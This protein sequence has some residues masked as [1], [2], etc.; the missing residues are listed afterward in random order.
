MAILKETPG[1]NDKRVGLFGKI[2]VEGDIQEQKRHFNAGLSNKS[3]VYD[4][5]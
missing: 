1:C 3:Y 4:N 5:L 2:A